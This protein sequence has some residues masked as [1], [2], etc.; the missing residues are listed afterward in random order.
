MSS[1]SGLSIILA[2]SLC[3]SKFDQAMC[4]CGVFCTIRI[5]TLRTPL[6]CD[7]YMNTLHLAVVPMSWQQIDFSYQLVRFGILWLILWKASESVLS[8]FLSPTFFCFCL[9]ILFFFFCHCSTKIL[10]SECLFVAL[11]FCTCSAPFKLWKGSRGHV[12][13]QYM[14]SVL[15]VKH[16]IAAIQDR[17]CC[18]NSLASS[19][20]IWITCDV[21]FGKFYCMNC[22][23]DA[24]SKLCLICLLSL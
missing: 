20:K 10:T 11:Q 16:H 2:S 7:F 1:H 8:P 13:L 23:L 18:F 21:T 22:G 3:V 4:C 19:R 12:V 6:T 17:D 15:L 9:V 24:G 5:S 14:F